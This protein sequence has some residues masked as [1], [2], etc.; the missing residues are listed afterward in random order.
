LKTQ[1]LLHLRDLPEAFDVAMLTLR[2][3]NKGNLALTWAKEGK[4]EKA[5]KL[6]R[7]MEH[8]FRPSQ[9]LERNC[10]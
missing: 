6:A 10:C 1:I 4:W 3:Q 5:L 9:S 8:D 7:S 2:D